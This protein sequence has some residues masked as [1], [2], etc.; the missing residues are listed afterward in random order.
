MAALRIDMPLLAYF[1]LA[2]RWA[3]PLNFGD[4]PKTCPRCYQVFTAAELIFTDGSA[5]HIP[6]KPYRADLGEICS[7][8]KS[9]SN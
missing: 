9:L 8:H 7:T 1:C 3:S 5:A 6:R 4:T 2:C